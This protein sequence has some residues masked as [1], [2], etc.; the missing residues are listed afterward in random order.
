MCEFTNMLGHNHI[1]IHWH[2]FMS[3]NET[4]DMWASTHAWP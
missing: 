2:S 3:V 4:R 1:A